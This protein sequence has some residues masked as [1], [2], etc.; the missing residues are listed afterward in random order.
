MPSPNIHIPPSQARH[1]NGKKAEDSPLHPSKLPAPDTGTNVTVSGEASYAPKSRYIFRP[2]PIERLPKELLHEIAIRTCVPKDFFALA[3]VNKRFRSIIETLYTR[4]S[5]LKKRFLPLRMNG[6]AVYA[7]EIRFL[8]RYFCHFGLTT[9]YSS[10]KLH[11]EVESLAR[12][13]LRPYSG[14]CGEWTKREKSCVSGKLTEGELEK[15]V[16]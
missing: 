9:L 14:I 1:D 16:G 4:A 3:L 2:Q 5:F 11:A 15:E 8:Y 6:K 12:R 10:S 13:T 7:G